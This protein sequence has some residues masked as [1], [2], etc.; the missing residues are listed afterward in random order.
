[1]SDPA[2]DEFR[3]FYAEYEKACLEKDA[4]FL[5]KLLPAEV[6][7]DEFA[8]VLEMSRQS[9]QAVAASGVEPTFEFSG[10]RCDV[11]YEGDLGDGVTNLTIDFYLVDGKWLK[12]DPS[13]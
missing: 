13:A 7:E 8:F 5:K 9:A 3:T 1:M 2:Q 4:E 6:P 11:V 12:Y 10:N